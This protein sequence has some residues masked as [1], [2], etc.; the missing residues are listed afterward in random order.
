MDSTSQGRVYSSN[1][2]IFQCEPTWPAGDEVNY[3]KYW[4]VNDPW[5][6]YIRKHWWSNC[7]VNDLQDSQN[8]EE[9]FFTEVEVL[10]VLVGADQFKTDVVED[11]AAP[12]QFTPI[13]FAK[14]NLRGLYHYPIHWI[15]Q[16]WPSPNHLDVNI[17]LVC[18]QVTPILRHRPNPSLFYCNQNTSS[19]RTGSWEFV[20]TV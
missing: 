11:S 19:R 15:I 12:W 6:D 2:N 1:R 17:P 4:T 18:F 13:A 3:I 14:Q 8:L 20:G 5:Q 10:V 7:V 9:V 16:F